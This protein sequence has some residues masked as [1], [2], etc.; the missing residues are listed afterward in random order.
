MT[1]LTD[2]ARGSAQLWTGENDEIERATGETEDQPQRI[3]VGDELLLNHEKCISNG[4]HWSWC[5]LIR[6]VSEST[7]L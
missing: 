5:H 6:A 3:D 4:V 2:A 1:V 7:K